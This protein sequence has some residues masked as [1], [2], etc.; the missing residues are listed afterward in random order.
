M[1]ASSVPCLSLSS[2]SHF[3]VIGLGVWKADKANLPDLIYEAIKIGY[4]H[5]DCASDYGNEVEVGLGLK[6]AIDKG[7]VKREELFI[8]SKLWC[9][10]HH[11]EHVKPA[12]ERTLQDL[13][14]D[15]L[16]LF[17]IHF[18]ISLEFVPFEKRYPAEWSDV[19][20]PKHAKISN[21]STR[22]T[23]EA[24]EDLMSTGY[25]KNIGVS[26]FSCV[27]LMDLLCYARIKPAVQQ[28]EIHPLLCCNRLV[29]LCQK[30]NIAVTAFSP[31]AATSYI[32]LFEEAK[33]V[34]NLFDHPTVRQ[35]A[36]TH[37]KTP[38]QVLLRWQ[39]DRGCTAVPKT[40]NIQRLKENLN[41]FDFKLSPAEV[42][43]L[44]AL[45]SRIRCND[46]GSFAGI[47]IWD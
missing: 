34:P 23:W 28:I 11:K 21:A 44:T 32:G 35:I 22:E 26:N 45:D 47:P 41:I 7:I 1:A 42:A 14:L 33:T 15:Y 31:F 4:R 10:Y 6:R 8:T 38:A 12:L 37:K 29:Q 46:P 20:D 39:I 2:G 25:V 40:S 9:T 36:S 43:S 18:P 3:P 17:L 24:M 30:N 19:G 5:F 13:Q 16:D 27:L